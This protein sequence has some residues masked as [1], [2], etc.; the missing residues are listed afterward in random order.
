MTA[1]SYA[2]AV[3]TRRAVFVPG[4]QAE[5]QG[6]AK[7]D[8]Y[9][10]GA[11]YPCFVG[12]TPH[13]LLAMGTL[14]AGDWTPREAAVFGAVGRSL[15]VALERTD[16][17]RQ[18]IKQRDTLDLRT[19]DLEAANTEL[20]AFT[21]SA[22]H[23]LRTPVRHVMGFSELAQKAL[24]K[25]PNPKANEYMEVVK[26]AA[27][28]M[29]SLI[30]GMLVLSRSGRQELKLQRVDLNE[31]VAQARRDVG[32]EFVDHPVRWRISELPQVQGDPGLL[33]QVMSNLLS[34]A[35]KY[36]G[37]RDLSEVRVWAEDGP[38]EW[39]IHI[40]D[41]GVG[42][43][44]QYAE[45][46]FGIFQRLHTEREFKGTGVGLATVRRIVQKHGGRVSAESDGTSGSTFSFWLPKP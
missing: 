27:T 33:Q 7:T 36:S 22:S 28:R 35:V 8:S 12:D 38:G 16:L 46:L 9:G 41:N 44:P 5:T 25:T 19:Q 23:D 26:Q 43:D 4:W 40:Q 34:N 10:A 39:V 1:P 14:R 3:Q 29:T 32:L 20:E 37:K 42:F 11:F 24:E 13:G 45:R 18:L 15:T 31:V 6:V 2:E 21:Y 30:D 17:S